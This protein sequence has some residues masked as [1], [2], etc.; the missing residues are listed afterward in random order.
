MCSTVCTQYNSVVQVNDLILH[1]FRFFF[2]F[3]NIIN[4]FE[5]HI[6]IPYNRDRLLFEC[7]VFFI[8]NLI[9]RSTGYTIIKQYNVY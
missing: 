6:I 2:V 4:L 3:E 1:L 9:A 7:K 5:R 8:E